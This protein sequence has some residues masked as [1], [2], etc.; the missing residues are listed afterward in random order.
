MSKYLQMWEYVRS[1]D[2]H[3]TA[4]LIEALE[5]ARGADHELPNGTRVLDVDLLEALRY[6]LGDLRKGLAS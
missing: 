4:Q 1:L 5:P 3:D 6:W 2:E